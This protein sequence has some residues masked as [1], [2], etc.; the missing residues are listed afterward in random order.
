MFKEVKEN[1]N[2]MQREV[3]DIFKDPHEISR[4]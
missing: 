2:M 4:G 1:M 3:E